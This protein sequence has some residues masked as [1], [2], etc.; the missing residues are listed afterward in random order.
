MIARQGPEHPLSVLEVAGPH[1]KQGVQYLGVKPQPTLL[2]D[3]VE[4]GTC[5]LNGGRLWSA[6]SGRALAMPWWGRWVL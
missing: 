5:C 1:V 4:L 3:P 2:D 6:C